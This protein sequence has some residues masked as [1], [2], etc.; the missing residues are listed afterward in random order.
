[1][2]QASLLAGYVYVVAYA[3]H[4]ASLYASMN[5]ERQ[6]LVPVLAAIYTDYNII[7]LM[8]VAVILYMLLAIHTKS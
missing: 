4:A 7:A 8:L 3:V 5:L 1:M 2:L 6:P